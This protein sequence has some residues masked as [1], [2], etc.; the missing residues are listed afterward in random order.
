MEFLR[1]PHLIR[2][3]FNG[4][5]FGPPWSFTSTSTWTW[6]GHPVSGP[7]HTTQRPIQT[8]SRFGSIPEEL[9][10]AAY[11]RS[12]DHSTKGTIS[13][14]DALYVLVGAKFQVLFHSPPGVLFTFPSQYYTLSVTREYLG[15]EGG[16]PG[17][18]QGFTCPV[19]LWILLACFQCRLRGYHPVS[20]L[21]PKRSAIFHTAYRSPNPRKIAS[22]GLAS[23][24]F[25]RHYWR[26]LC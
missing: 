12:P 15:L 11:I 24:A 9:N 14:G 16:P 26:N 18:P 1:Y 7:M 5:R 21:F 6:I 2:R 22:S 4:G 19:V 20:P 3:L 10:L 23:S 8:C 25:A 17:F 13:R